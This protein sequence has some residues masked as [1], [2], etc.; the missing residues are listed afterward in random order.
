[1]TAVTATT[2]DAFRPAL[3]YAPRN[4]WLNDPNGLIFH[5]G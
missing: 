3:H 5:E 2:A 1:M 4:T